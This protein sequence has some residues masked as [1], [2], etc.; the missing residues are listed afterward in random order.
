MGSG[1]VPAYGETPAK[2]LA[3]MYSSWEI[4]LALMLMAI[5]RF[6]PAADAATCKL[7]QIVRTPMRQPHGCIHL[8]V[9]PLM[10]IF[11]AILTMLPPLHNLLKRAEYCIAR[12]L[13]LKEIPHRLSEE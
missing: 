8:T 1:F 7:R 9:V 5:I 6:N 2:Q 11:V 13:I 4:R 3:V 12:T 10:L